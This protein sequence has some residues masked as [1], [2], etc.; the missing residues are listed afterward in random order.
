M[1]S[2]RSLELF[3]SASGIQAIARHLRELADGI[4]DAFGFEL[5]VQ[6]TLVFARTAHSKPACAVLRGQAGERELVELVWGQ[7][8]VESQAEREAAEVS[9]FKFK[10]KP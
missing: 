10:L 5:A 2:A 1:S 9:N 7:T 6:Y 4:H 3:I 8:E